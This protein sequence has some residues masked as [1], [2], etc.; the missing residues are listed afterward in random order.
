EG[1]R[2]RIHSVSTIVLLPCDAEESGRPANQANLAR[3]RIHQERRSERRPPCNDLF[4]ESLA[5]IVLWR[6]KAQQARHR[7]RAPSSKSRLLPAH[8]LT[9][10]E[11]PASGSGCDWLLRAG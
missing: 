4:P 1:H 5:V 2:R 3:F 11:S 10:A 9:R 8:Y 7:S 6:S